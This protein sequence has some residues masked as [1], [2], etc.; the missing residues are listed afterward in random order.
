MAKRPTHCFRWSET[1]WRRNQSRGRLSSG[2]FICQPHQCVC[3]SFVDARGLHGL[4]CRKSAPQHVRHSLINDIL[5]RVIKKAQVQACKEPVGLS[6]SDGKRPDGATLI[7]RSHGKPLAW[8]VTV[9]TQSHITWTT[10]N[11]GVAAEKAACSKPKKYE[12]LSITHFLFH[13]LW[14]QEVPG[15]LKQSSSQMTS[16]RESPRSIQ[17]HSRHNSCSNG[18]PSQSREAM[19]WRFRT[20][21][22][23]TIIFQTQTNLQKR[24]RLTP[25]K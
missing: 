2:S 22:K 11:A 15:T 24:R 14:K 17:S 4:S 21:S 12:H 23:M 25:E 9:P 16:E 5:W 6:R 18:F 1:V 20:H 3:G 10:S 8:D 13:S 7:P 19:P